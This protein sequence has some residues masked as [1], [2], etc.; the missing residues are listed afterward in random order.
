MN[1]KHW[2]SIILN[3]EVSDKEIFEL[4]NEAYNLLIKK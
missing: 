4:V 3:D 2:V 1:K